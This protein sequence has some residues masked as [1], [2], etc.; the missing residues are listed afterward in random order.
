MD[1]SFTSHSAPITLWAPARRKAQESRPGPRLHR[2]EGPIHNRQEMVTNL[3][4]SG[5][6]MMSRA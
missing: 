3:A 1:A 6:R 2:R 5:S 4:C